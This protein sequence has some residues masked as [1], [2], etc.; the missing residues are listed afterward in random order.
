MSHIDEKGKWIRN[1]HWSKMGLL[2]H[3]EAEPKKKLLKEYGINRGESIE[4][5]LDSKDVS[6]SIMAQ[7]K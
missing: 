5:L 1:M 7:E 3:H 4:K 6:Y 2:T